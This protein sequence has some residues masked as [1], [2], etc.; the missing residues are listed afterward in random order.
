MDVFDLRDRLV[1]DYADYVRSFINIRDPQIA[2]K[3]EEKLQ[4]GVLWPEPL[5]QL[6]PSFEPGGSIPDLISDHVLDPGCEKIFA[7]KRDDR[8]PQPL[9]LYRH[10]R[11]A[12]HAARTG[13]SYVLTT[14]TGSGKS[15]AYIVPIVDF[16]L[17]NGSGKGIKAIVV[18]PMNA[19][20]NS[21]F[22]ELDKFINRG[23][24][25]NR[26]PVRF[27]RYTGQ[28]K[29]PERHETRANPPD[30]LL[31]NYVM[32]E[33]LLTRP[34]DRRLIEHARGLRFLVLDELHTYRGRQGADVAMLVRRVRDACR[35]DQLQCVG[36]SATLATGGTKAE[37]RQA[38]A[39]VA[40]RLFGTRVEPAQIIGETLQR[41]TEELDFAD[42]SVRARLSANVQAAAA[43]APRDYE[44]FLRYPLASWIETTIGLTR[45]DDGNL[46]RATPM[47][48]TGADGAG[49]RL[50]EQL[51]LKDH[52][53]CARAIKTCLLTGFACERPDNHL[54][55]FAFRLHQF[56]SR[57]ES[58]FA[59]L[60]AGPDRYV[61]V[62]GQQY[63]P[64]DRRRILLPMAFC[65]ACGQD[66]Y[67]VERYQEARN[68]P[69][70]YA[71]RALTASAS[72][73]DG[74]AGFLYVSAEDPWP[75]DGSPEWFDRLP[76]DWI[77][78]GRGNGLRVRSDRRKQLPRTVFVKPPGVEN[79]GGLR[80]QF[81][82]AP[83]RF[84]LRCGI[85][86]A[87]RQSDLGKLATLGTGGRSTATTTLCLSAIR[88][89]R[90]E[91][92]LPPDARKVLSFTDNRQD[93][94]LQAGHFN[95]FVEIGLLRSAL[96]NAALKRGPQGLDHAEIAHEVFRLLDLS[97]DLYAV[98][99]S[100]QFA[101][102][103]RTKSALKDVLGYRLYFDLRRGWRVTSPNLE[104]CGLLDI[105]Y[106]S[107]DEIVRAESLWRDRHPA[108]AGASPEDRLRVCT[109]VL[110]YLRREL[111]INVNYLE[112]GYQD[113]IRRNSDQQ[114]RPPW[115]IDE[116]ER[117]FHAPHVRIGSRRAGDTQD[118]AYLS[119]RGRVG[120][121]LRRSSTF[122]AY[123]PPASKRLEDTER[124]CADLV[125]ALV[126]GGLIV[127]TGDGDRPC[128][129][130]QA[131]CMRWVARDGTK[132]YHDPI[133][134]AQP[135][136]EGG[137]PNPFFVEYYKHHGLKNRNLYA[138]EHTAAVTNDDREE[139]ERDF[140]TAQL[141]LLFCSPTM[142]LGVD[143]AQLNAVNL[144]NVPPTPANYAQRGG[145]A[146]RSGQPAL[147]FTYCTT[148][149]PHDQYFF[150][151]P[152]LMVSG[153]VAP[154][155]LELA[156]EDLIR[157]HI[158][159][160]WLA[161][162]GASLERSLVELLDLGGAEP[163][164]ELIPSKRHDLGREHAVQNARQRAVKILDS[165]RAEL[166]QATWWSDEGFA[167]ILGH[168]M[169]RLDDACGRWRSLY[170]AA[171]NQL[172]TQNSV[173]LD[174]SRSNAEKDQ[175]RRL[176]READVQLRLLTEAR[177]VVQDDFYSYRYFASEGFLPGYSFPRLPLSSFIPGRRART[178]RDEYI[179]RP[180]FL[181]ISEFGPRA[182][183][184]HEGVRYRVNSVLMSASDKSEEGLITF[185]AK[186]CNACGYLHTSDQIAGGNVDLCQRCG[187][188]LGPILTTL[189]QLRN[190]STRRVDRITSDE[191]ERQ[192]QGF[193]LRTGVRFIEHGGRPASLRADVQLT[194]RCIARMEY[195]DSATVWRMN[196]GWKRRK[197]QHLM[198]F[199]L[200]VERGF[201]ARNNDDPDD[202]DRDPMTARV[203]RVIPF[204]RDTRNVLL[205]EP[206]DGQS[207]KFMATLQAALKKAIQVI[208]QLEDN[209]LAVE[210]LPTDDQRRLLLIYEAAEG[211]AGVLRRLVDEPQAMAGVARTALE[212]LHYD[213]DTG[214]DQ[215]SGEDRCEA[216]CYDCLMG[217][218][219]QR[220]HELLDR[221]T[222]REFLQQ[223]SD[224][225]VHVSSTERS[226]DELYQRLVNLSESNLER[227]FLQY[228]YDGDFRL[229]SDAQR[230]FESCGTRPDFIYDTQRTAIY[231]DGPHHEYP[232]RAARDR[233]QTHRLEDAGWSVIRIADRD[234]GAAVRAYPE[235]FRGGR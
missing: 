147:V 206:G 148:G 189:F 129:Q 76:D 221:A 8:P 83:F 155:R 19:L 116:N 137:R 204:V 3:V 55:T 75:D 213:P 27:A 94:S 25:N 183:I 192:R 208:Y 70:R 79:E 171:R 217:Y 170:R 219:N 110:D 130:L 112:Y 224:A 230:Y 152:E 84:C 169:Q 89:L 41:A 218:W 123:S 220:D 57:G 32:L 172:T 48:I 138:R 37:Q 200:D 113:K 233:E 96:Y 33:L 40:T 54:P 77:E 128:Y 161:E 211:G 120:L 124:I 159:A 131:S 222:V 195:G 190:V 191:E 100:A 102:Q 63:V 140:R 127:K 229:P 46:A 36:T 64:G 227:S 167:L 234:W 11:D 164:L 175:A 177:N 150:G 235:V 133:L 135:S 23:F 180:R 108:L 184:Y 165:V 156:N 186:Q 162:T 216:A 144:R 2:G 111:V 174:A 126:E 47:C 160:V 62:R 4:Q 61:T 38:I 154:P 16:V 13:K 122:P 196:I 114:L 49:A 117:F 203:Q 145:R 68:E 9:R 163:S 6:N 78:P 98:N 139:R 223:L 179:S 205:F 35:A 125:E 1:A 228:L 231:V 193:E 103:S 56:I 53:L 50:A 82:P 197:E 92:T 118:F 97:P 44:S 143:I 65:R 34:D 226:R 20:A 212:L 15:L 166:G 182:L 99:P 80:M 107:I 104:Q 28:E 29:E 81:V 59:S 198:G 30:I 199:M 85:S 66:Y 95:D 73:D 142:E 88:W 194:D 141:P 105:V 74:E 10:Q 42:P 202:D 207:P 225:T 215:E 214:E 18:Y 109:A 181:A 121:F 58:V 119:P 52:D 132:P 24:P 45:D 201:W 185:T 93:A 157:A 188:E 173:L 91:E 86:Y 71:K 101:E 60:Q 134:T 115:A 5:I 168:V 7:I 153:A 187:A 178:D 67:V 209:E 31:T 43:D 151:H 149:S 17:R 51:G 14:G 12:I 136:A 87:G 26:G 176:H 72:A 21:Q 106:E 90:Q 210:P 39:N 69:L 146:G 232:E 158:Q 22:Q